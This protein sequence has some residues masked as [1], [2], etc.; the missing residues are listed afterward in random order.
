MTPLMSPPHP[1][2]PHL[3]AVGVDRQWAELTAALSRRGFLGAIAL[4]ATAFTVGC[5]TSS[6][7]DTA[8]AATRAVTTPLGTYDIPVAPQ[9]V[10]VIDSRLDLEPALALEL[11]VI[12]T[13]YDTPAPWLPPVDARVLTAPVDLEEVL[14]LAPD[15]IV[16][17]NLD[18]E[19]W[20]A[21]KLLDIAPVITTEFTVPWK[22]NLTRLADWLGRT[23]TFDRVLAEYDAVAAAFRARHRDTLAR[24]RFGIVSLQQ[25]QFYLVHNGGSRLPPQVLADV[26]G[27]LGSIGGLSDSDSFGMESLELLDGLDGLIVLAPRGDLGA[28]AGDALWQRVPAVAAGRVQAIDQR[29]QFGSVYSAIE[30]VAQFDTLLSR[31]G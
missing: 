24:A 2:R 30:L 21:P 6:G 26:G 11:P 27:T 16:C 7:S 10:V 8:S 19:M 15:L 3:D 1:A 9:R 25:D 18:S 12:A 29:L 28:L 23:A 5:G 20:P 4:G 17:V 14:G 31:L 22:E 13:S